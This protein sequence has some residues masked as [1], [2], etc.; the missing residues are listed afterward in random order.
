MGFIWFYKTLHD[1]HWNRLPKWSKG[2]DLSG[3]LSA[4]LSHSISRLLFSGLSQRKKVF[5][6]CRV[7]AT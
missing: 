1:N 5:K 3:L 7:I 2:L 4:A 6:E